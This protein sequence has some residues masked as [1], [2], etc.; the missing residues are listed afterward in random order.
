[1]PASDEMGGKVVLLTGATDGIGRAAALELAR[2]GARLA[3]VGRSREKADGVLREVE[4]VSSPGRHRVLLGDLS[5]LAQVRTV[6]DAFLAGADRLD[7]LANNVGAVFAGRRLS[8]DGFEMTFALNHLGPF[9]LTHLLLDL[10]RRTPGARVVTTSSGAHHMSRLDLS[11]VA[12]SEKG[13]AAF[14]AYGDSKLANVLFTRELARRLAGSG[15][16][17]NCFHPGWVAS[18]FGLDNPGLGPKLLALVG[19][20]LARTPV[21]GAETLVWLA[22]SAEAAGRSGEYFQDRRPGR[23]SRRARDP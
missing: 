21:K 23:L 17:A 16:R 10:L 2:R 4:A 12:R 7:V 1:M 13:Y 18:R 15:V 6:A 22:S 3:L 19:P 11:D 5:S 9:L 14:R 8:A 20:L